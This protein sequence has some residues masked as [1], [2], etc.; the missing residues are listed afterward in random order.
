MKKNEKPSINAFDAINK[1]GPVE[2]DQTFN[3]ADQCTPD[4]PQCHQSGF[5]AHAVQ[6]TSEELKSV[7]IY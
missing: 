6:K 2:C 4:S 5:R 7:N 3:L 1:L